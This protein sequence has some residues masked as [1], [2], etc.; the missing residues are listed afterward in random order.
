MAEPTP[1][2]D[3]GCV[4]CT[5]RHDQQRL[6][7]VCAEGEIRIDLDGVATRRTKAVIHAPKTVRVMRENIAQE[8]AHDAV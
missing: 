6:L 1:Q 8:A 4:V 5:I 3:I 7:F 2:S